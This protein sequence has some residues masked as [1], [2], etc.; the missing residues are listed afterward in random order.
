MPVRTAGEPLSMIH[1]AVSVIR[2]MAS[3]IAVLEPLT[4]EDR[5]SATIGQPQFATVL[6]AFS[7][8]PPYFWR[9]SEYGQV[10]RPAVLLWFFGS[11]MEQVLII[12]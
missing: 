6:V 3:D 12:L 1:R 11:E 2:S 9:Q 5:I 10:F 7:P 8:A 4:M